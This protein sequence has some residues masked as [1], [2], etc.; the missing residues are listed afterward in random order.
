MCPWKYPI[1][2]TMHPFADVMV[3][4]CSSICSCRRYSM[5]ESWFPGVMCTGA[6]LA[7]SLMKAGSSS[8][9][10]H[11]VLGTLCFTSPSRMMRSGVV[12]LMCEVILAS[13]LSVWLGM[14]M[15]LCWRSHSIPRCRSEITRHLMVLSVMSAGSFRIGVSWTDMC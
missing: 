5:S 12:C 14:V 4:R 6:W 7:S 2:S 9:S 13:I 3:Q 11:D 8:C 1:P 10:C 15:P